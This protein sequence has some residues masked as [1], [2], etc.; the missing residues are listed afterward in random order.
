MLHAIQTRLDSSELYF[1]EGF[2][3]IYREMYTCMRMLKD[4][5]THIHTG[6][7]HPA[8][9]APHRGYTDVSGLPTIPGHTAS[10]VPQRDLQAHKHLVSQ[11]SSQKDG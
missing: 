10:A 5:Q 6:S 11:A 7:I 8:K 9:T 4:R 2:M 1:M 3:W